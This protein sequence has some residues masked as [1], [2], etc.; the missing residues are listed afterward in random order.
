MKFQG[1]LSILQPHTLGTQQDSCLSPF[2]FNVLIEKLSKVFYG[3]GIILLCYADDLALVIPK[4]YHQVTA[5]RVLELLLQCCSSLD[6]KINP[7]KSRYM[8]FGLPS[9]AQPIQLDDILGIWFDTALSF[10]PHVKYF[11]ERIAARVKVLHCLSGR[12]AGASV[13]VKRRVYTAAVRSVLDYSAPCLSGLS[14][15]SYQFL[16]VVQNGAMRAILGVPR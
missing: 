1:H 10:R 15:T 2:L 7:G 5:P 3:Q 14:N 12:G 9:L 4:R 8:T 11:R 6:L 13:E 16:E